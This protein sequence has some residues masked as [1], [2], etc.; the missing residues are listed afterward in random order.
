MRVVIAGHCTGVAEC[1]LRLLG[2]VSQEKDLVVGSSVFS[3]GRAS[4]F[5][6]QFAGEGIA[7]TGHGASAKSLGRRPPFHRGTPSSLLLRSKIRRS[8]LRAI[9]RS[10]RLSS[11]GSGRTV[12][13]ALSAYTGER[14]SLERFLKFRN[15]SASSCV[16]KKGMQTV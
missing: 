5:V 9:V 15:P 14:S 6:D 3:H 12:G 2:K 13:E 16:S 11:A 8:A 1:C 7:N 10:M 4:L